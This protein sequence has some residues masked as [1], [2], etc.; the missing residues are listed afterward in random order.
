MKTLWERFLETID[1]LDNLIWVGR[2]QNQDV[3]NLENLRAA[4]V[5]KFEAVPQP[6]K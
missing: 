2:I 1:R 5:A 3:T 4:L 6:G